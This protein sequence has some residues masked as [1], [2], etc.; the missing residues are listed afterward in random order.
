MVDS[1]IEPG[2][3]VAL[4]FTKY[5]GSRHWEYDLLALGVDSSGVWLGGW[6]GDLCSRPGKVIDPG[7]HWVTLIP[8]LGD[9]VATWNAPG[10]VLGA[11]LY[12]DVTDSPRWVRDPTG[13]PEW[14]LAAVDLDL[15]V[16]RRFTGQAY[17]DDEDEFEEHRVGWGYPD[18]L[19]RRA[20][21]TA[22]ALLAAVLAHAEPFGEV[23]TAWLTRCREWTRA[24]VAGRRGRR[25]PEPSGRCR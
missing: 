8:H 2:A 4:R 23:G 7:A 16:V 22:D 25:G 19:A 18:G 11:A 3:A 17:I 9:W 13:E 1:P 20:R 10:G 15:D 14:T 6:P 24:E 5:D 12:I 21:E